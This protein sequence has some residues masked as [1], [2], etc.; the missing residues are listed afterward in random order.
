MKIRVRYLVIAVLALALLFGSYRTARSNTYDPQVRAGVNYF[1]D[2]AKA[3]LPLT[4]NLLSA[5]KSGDINKAKAAYVEARPP[6]EEIEVLAASFTKEDTDIDARPYAIEGGETSPEFRGFHRIEALIYRDGDLQAAIPYG[7]QLVAS[8][9]SL[10]T[11]LNKPENFNAP[12]NFR[13]MLNLA[14]ELPAKKISS[15]EETWSDQSLLIFKHNWIGIHSQFEPY[16]AIL[17]RAITEKVESAYQACLSTIEPF[18]RPGQVAA[19]PY[20]TVTP[21]QRGA[22]VRASYRYR[23]A[24][25][26]AKAALNI[27]D[28]Q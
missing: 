15:E 13:G 17:G 24:L 7:E 8:V 18:F 26:E 12:L 2:Q 28:P 10:I 27:A 6:Y 11:E 22:I 5:L 19:M 4:E 9:K 21:E 14:T 1:L 3:Q 20:S 25:L 16:K 23:E